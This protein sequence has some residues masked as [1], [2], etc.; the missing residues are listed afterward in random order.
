MTDETNVPAV[1]FGPTGFVAPAEADVRAGVF[2]DI[3]AAF[4]GGLNPADESPQGQLATSLAAIV[5]EVNDTFVLYTNQVDP[6]YASGRMQDAIA[7]IYNL[8]RLPSQP[9][10]LSVICT[11]LVGVT[12]PVGALVNDPAGNIYSCT[13][14]GPIAST[15]DVTLSFSAVI[16][17]PTAVPSEL[18]IYQAIPGWDATDVVSGVVG[19]ATETR[20]EFETRRQ[21]T[22]G[23]NSIGSLPSIRG[24][25]LGVDG[26]VDAYVTE[27]AT[28]S[29]VVFNGFTLAA[30]SL[31]VAAY[32]GLAQDIG[33][34][35]WRKK[36]PGC[37]YNGSTTVTV[38]DDNSGYSA[39]FPSYS[40]KFQIPNVLQILFHVTIVN[41]SQVPA[42]AATQVQNA[43]LGAFAGDDGGPRAQIGS[44]IYGSRYIAPI[45]ALGSWAVISAL[46][47]GS[48]NSTAASVVGSISGTTM[49]VT[50]VVSGTL[51]VG[52]T[53]ASGSALGGTGT[54]EPGTKITAFLTGAGGTGTYRVGI[55]KNVVSASI[56][57][58]LPTVGSVVV[59]INQVPTLVAA[60]ILVDTT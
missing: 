21:A 31:Y 39:P 30:N 18:A 5:G 3:D 51:A 22:L 52:Q 34:A 45:E 2:A 27:N 46:T 20:A 15:G 50:S 32:G 58:V 6:A 44:T 42:D 48:I 37:A 36:A 19:N 60:N 8:E 25:V 24:E 10:I 7:R 16:Y 33:E 59:Q 11:G 43:L 47:I 54:I 40:V 49:T 12:I 29:P 55:S 56:L 57:A 13:G 28:G 14:S 9:T 26:V 38:E 4:G 41:G 53:L 1:E 35:I 17:G 23:R